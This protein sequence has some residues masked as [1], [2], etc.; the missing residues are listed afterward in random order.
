MAERIVPGSGLAEKER[1]IFVAHIVRQQSKI[2]NLVAARTSNG[3]R[4]DP[5]ILMADMRLLESEVAELRNRVI[6]LECGEKK[7][8]ETARRTTWDDVVDALTMA[9][10]ATP[11]EIAARYRCNVNHIHQLIHANR[12]AI[13]KRRE[14]TRTYYSLAVKPI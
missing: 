11:F 10:E 14:G 5:D 7:A 4:I 8:Q 1:R 6:A 13:K 12:A 3:T 2:D 9:G